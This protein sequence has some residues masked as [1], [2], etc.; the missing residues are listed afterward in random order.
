MKL[1]SDLFKVHSTVLFISGLFIM[2]TAIVAITGYLLD[3]RQ[4]RDWYMLTE[5]ALP[6]AICFLAIGFNMVLLA[7]RLNGHHAE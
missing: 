5:M 6:T 1:S 7:I 2:L 3:I 4:L